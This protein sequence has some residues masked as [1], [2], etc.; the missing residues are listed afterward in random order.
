V[1][2]V[3]FQR[4]ANNPEALIVGNTVDK[5]VLKDWYLG[6]QYHVE[7]FAFSGG[8]LLSDAQVQG[9]VGAMAAFAP[10]AGSIEPVMQNKAY[11]TMFG[12]MDS[13]AVQAM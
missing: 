8:T 13:L 3:A 6:T 11:N 7:Q 10:Q 5:L 12:R 9:L 2:Q 4:A 1:P